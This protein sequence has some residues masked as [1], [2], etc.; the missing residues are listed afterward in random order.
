MRVG[1][2]PLAIVACT[3]ALFVIAMRPE[4]LDQA[5]QRGSAE[6]TPVMET[7]YHLAP[8]GDDECDVGTTPPHWECEAAGKKAIEAEGITRS[9]WQ[10]QASAWPHVPRG[11][12]VREDD[13]K[14]HYSHR[15]ARGNKNNGYH[16]LVCRQLKAVCHDVANWKDVESFDCAHYEKK[17]WCSVEGLGSAWVPRWGLFEDWRKP[18]DYHAGQA[19]CACGRDPVDTPFNPSMTAMFKYPGSHHKDCK[20][21]ALFEL[22]H[23]NWEDTDFHFTNPAFVENCSSH[24]VEDKTCNYLVLLPGKKCMGCSQTPDKE[25]QGQFRKTTVLAVD[26]A[27]PTSFLAPRRGANGCPSGSEKISSAEEC[28]TVATGLGYK[29]VGEDTANPQYPG[30]CFTNDKEKLAVGRAWWNPSTGGNS[31][32]K[33][34][35]CKAKAGAVVDT[36]TASDSPVMTMKSSRDDEIEESDGDDQKKGGSGSTRPLLLVFVSVP[37][38]SFVLGL[39]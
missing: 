26:K 21:S 9:N 16:R 39:A 19:C 3:H 14:I 17:N 11:C 22:T 34:L 27:F 33:F 24:C 28:D 10:Y 31:S 23:P 29:Y 25:A 12:S 6:D 7:V 35:L 5:A 18:G 30:G 2:T 37:I 1:H 20:D 36:D 32:N 13:G 15:M 4:Q 38:V 8:K